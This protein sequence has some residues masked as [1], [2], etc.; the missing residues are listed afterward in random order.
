MGWLIGNVRTNITNA[1]QWQKEAKVDPMTGFWNKIYSEQELTRIC[2]DSKGILMMIDLDNFKPVNDLYGHDNGDKVLTRFADCIRSCTRSEDF[3]GRVGGDEFIAFIQG[4]TEESAV[5]EK[6][7]YLNEEIAKVGVSLIGETF[8]IPLG[9]SIG[10]VTVPDEGTDFTELY[11]KADKALYNVKQNGKHGYDL[12]RDSSSV[13]QDSEEVQSG[14]L[15]GLRVILGERGN[16]K[17][18]YLVD[19]DK[20]Q[21]VYRLFVRM[22]KRTIVNIWIVQFMVSKDGV[23]EVPDEIMEKFVEVVKLSLRSNDVIAPNGKNKVI[24]IMTETSS[25]NGQTP[26]DRIINKWKETQGVDGYTL[27]YETE[28]MA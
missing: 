22:S 10:G 23:E 12:Y 21:M 1:E 2:A 7:R 20:L 17:G 4:T 25:T 15:A 14:G 27:S 13:F 24:I 3:I 16:N 6:A 9:V 5:A 8:S 28:D 18:A 19:F 26:I 11:K